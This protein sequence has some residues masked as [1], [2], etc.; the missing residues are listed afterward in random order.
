[1]EISILSC[2]GLEGSFRPLGRW[3]FTVLNFRLFK[4]FRVWCRKEFS[5]F[6]DG[7]TPSCGPNL[8]RGETLFYQAPREGTAARDGAGNRTHSATPLFQLF[9]NG[10]APSGTVIFIFIYRDHG[11]GPA[12]KRSTRWGNFFSFSFSAVSKGRG[13]GRLVRIT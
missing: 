12:E 5:R 6:A 1:M 8:C 4:N 7:C 9:K 13:L 2:D 11:P 10:Q 3:Q